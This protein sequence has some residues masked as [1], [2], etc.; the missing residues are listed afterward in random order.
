MTSLQARGIKIDGVGL[1]GHF[2][3]GDTPDEASQISNLESFTAL[4]VEVAYTEVDVRFSSLPPSTSG[5]QQQSVDYVNTVAACLG[6]KDCV[7]ITL[8]DYT[9]L[10]SWIPSTFAGEG[11]ACLW[12]ANFTTKPAYTS[13]I[14]LLG[15]S[16]TSSTVM[17]SST[18]T[19]KSTTTSS[20]LKTTSTTS[21]SGGTVP[22]WG[23]CGGEG[24][25]GG[26]ACA[27]PYTCTYSNAWYSQV[28]RFFCDSIGGIS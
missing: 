1:Q 26:T 10:Y 24:W 2:I 19:S 20:S 4:G 27:S 23:Q 17:S 14:S 18:S 22:H 8:W 6:V 9:D 28:S 12:N 21:S 25:T 15:G 11:D 16:V 5:Y 13:V 7:G 3:V